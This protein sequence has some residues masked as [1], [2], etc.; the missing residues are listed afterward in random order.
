MTLFR[1]SVEAWRPLTTQLANGKPIEFLMA[2][3]D[4][5]SGGYPCDYTYLGEAGIG[6]LDPNN[7]ASVGTNASAQHPSPPCPAT[8]VCDRDPSTG[9]QTAASCPASSH[10]A[11]YAQLTDDQRVR[12]VQP[13]LDYVDKCIDRA[14]SDLAQYGYSNWTP[15]TTSF[16]SMVKMGHVAP[17]RIPT[18][19]AQG[20]ACNLGVPPADW[21]AL[22]FCGPFP[23]TP[24][25]WTDN[26]GWVGSYA[27]G[28]KAFGTWPTWIPITLGIL[29]VVAAAWS[30][31]RYKSR[32]PVLKSLFGF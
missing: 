29:G 18:M 9:K 20:L 28:L 8:L 23:N 16:W 10:A 6:Q 3:L 22:M 12:Q 32:L 4:K 30:Y 19:L 27:T 2:W 14:S 24:Q 5:E 25:S 11:G 15:D 13:W 17:A 1:S 31:N 7:M 26:A 21:D